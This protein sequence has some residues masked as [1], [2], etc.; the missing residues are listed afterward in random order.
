[1]SKYVRSYAYSAQTIAECRPNPP[2]LAAGDLT[3]QYGVLYFARSIMISLLL[4][5]NF[6]MASEARGACWIRARS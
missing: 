2:L 3:V 5:T 1:M 4:A 6:V